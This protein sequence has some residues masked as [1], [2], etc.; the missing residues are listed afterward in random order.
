MRP[1]ALLFS[2]L[3]FTSLTAPSLADSA[4]KPQYVLISFDNA[5]SNELWQR[6]RSL[7]DKA[8]ARFTYFLS[9]VFLIDRADRHAYKAP[10]HGAGKSNI[11]FAGS[12]TD[13]AARLGNIWQA[14]NEGHEIA[15][16]ACGHFDGKNWSQ[17]DWS[18]ELTAYKQALSGAWTR[19]KA[20]QEP[21]EWQK[22]VTDEVR[23]FRAPYLSTSKGMKAALRKEGFVFD[24]STVSSGPANPEKEDGLYRFSLPTIKEGPS[25]RPVLAMDYNLFVRHTGGSERV[26]ENNIFQNRTYS[27][28]LAAFEKQYNGERIPL[29]IGLHFTLMNG[30]AYWRALERFATDVCRIKG[31]RC[32]TYSQYLSETRGLPM[33]VTVA[34]PG[35][36]DRS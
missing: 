19:N 35:N 7:A 13:I 33:P 10:D 30:D 23:G 31:V 28:F 16:H 22:F 8:N 24:A 25:N 9:C 2:S 12:K 27:A 18:K 21:E 4:P 20:G 14:R 29:Q 6:S 1:S 32:V 26:D 34:D 17:A 5:G 11:G 15:S 36:G 3:L